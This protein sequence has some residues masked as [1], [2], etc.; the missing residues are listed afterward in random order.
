MLISKDQFLKF[1]SKMTLESILKMGI[2]LIV[3]FILLISSFA[4]F[5][6]ISI[7]KHQ[8]V[9]QLSLQATYPHTQSFAQHLQAQPQILTHEY[10]RLMRA[11]A[12]EAKHVKEYP[13][14]AIEDD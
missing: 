11:Y 6:P 14:M 10:L 3:I 12:Y 1:K 5:R 4:L 8:H 2:M 9:S 13:A 7:E